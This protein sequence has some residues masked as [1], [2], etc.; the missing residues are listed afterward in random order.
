VAAHWQ[1]RMRTAAG[2][3]LVR[4]LAATWRFRQINY[5]PLRA[6][7]RPGGGAPMLYAFWHAQILS[8]LALHR[9]EGVAVVISEHR[10]GEIIARAAER[11]GCTTI[12]GSSSRGAV[13]ALRAMERGLA[14]GREVV[15]TPDGPRGPAERF[16]QGALVAAHRA[17]VPVVLAAAATVR[18]WRLT[19]WDRFSIP[20]PYATIVVAY[21]GP[22]R[23]TAATA[24]EAAQ[25]AEVFQERLVSLNTLARDAARDA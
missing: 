25:E 2:I 3:G 15:V 20:K 22:F 9:G 4:A 18:E 12:R 19:T 21:S 14:E 23:V 17:D 6:I 24:R 16:A 7:R 1:T 13:G 8:F 11:F 5:E 10:D